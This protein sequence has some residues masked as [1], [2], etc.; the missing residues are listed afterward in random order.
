[1]VLKEYYENLQKAKK[2]KEEAIFMELFGAGTLI[3]FNFD[4]RFQ[5][6]KNGM[7]LRFGLGFTRIRRTEKMS[8]PLQINYLWGESDEHLEVGIGTTFF[9][10][11]SIKGAGTL[12]TGY[13]YQSKKKNL[14][15][16]VTADF[17]LSYKSPNPEIFPALGFSIGH[18]L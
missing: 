15:L 2:Q 14:L 16:R 13:R 7:G 5:K 4:T 6:K 17:F 11:N 3:S 10:S 12:T 9:L 8:V 1:M 18:A